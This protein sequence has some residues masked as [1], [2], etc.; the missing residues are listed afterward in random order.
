VG[1][2]GDVGYTLGEHGKTHSG[3]GSGSAPPLAVKDELP[4]SL[5]AA[6]EG[7]GHHT[8]HQYLKSCAVIIAVLPLAP[9]AVVVVVPV[10]VPV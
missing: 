1:G 10:L 7:S 4:A 3:S 6:A 5:A 2:A 8:F 9:A